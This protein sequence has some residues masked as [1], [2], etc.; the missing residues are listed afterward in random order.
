MTLFSS[1][2]PV[3]FKG[4]DS[5]SEFAYRVCDKDRVVRGKLAKALTAT[6]RRAAQPCRRTG[7]R[8]S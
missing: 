7:L 4:P 3:G 1:V 6:T 2:E 8:R 5:T